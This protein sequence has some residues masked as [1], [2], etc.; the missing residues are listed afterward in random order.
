VPLLLGP[1]ALPVLGSWAQELRGEAPPSSPGWKPEGPGRSPAEA[2]PLIEFLR[3]CATSGEPFTFNALHKERQGGRNYPFFVPGYTGHVTISQN[4]YERAG[5][6]GPRHLLAAMRRD[7]RAMLQAPAGWTLVE[8]DFASCHGAIGYALSGDV[9]L[10]ADLALDFH[11]VT[12]DRLATEAVAAEKRRSLGKGVNISLLFGATPHRI[13]EMVR[14]FLGELPNRAWAEGAWEQ[15]W[16]RY[17]Q[18]AAFRDHVQAL[19]RQAQ[20]QNRALEVEAPSGRVSRFSAS[21]VR[22]LVRKGSKKAP[23]PSGTWRSIFSAS[24]RAVE[25]D[26]MSRTLLHFHEGWGLHR[27]RPVLPIYD[28]LLVAAP[29]DCEELVWRGLK[30]AGGQA[31]QELGMPALRLERKR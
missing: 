17:P 16:A 21:E 13:R 12:G 23:G 20:A 22:G 5:K 26:L 9:Q 29:E 15:W 4:R 10:G 14:T 1:E 11:Q 31:A 3:T 27:G 30:A 7:V 24:F 2:A 19:V 25:G 18:L 6:S 8:G 28:G